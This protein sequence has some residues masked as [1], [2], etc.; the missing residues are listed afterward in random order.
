MLKRITSALQQIWRYCKIGRQN[1]TFSGITL[2]PLQLKGISGICCTFVVKRINA[3]DGL[4][5]LHACEQNVFKV[6]LSE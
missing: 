4:Q 1:Q 3:G 5:K 6:P 2:L